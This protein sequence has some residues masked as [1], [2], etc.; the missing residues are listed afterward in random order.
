MHGCN[1][2]TDVIIA[3]A[4][5]ADARSLALMPCCYAQTAA[6]APDCL[7]SALGVALAADIQRTYTLEG[8]GYRVGWRAI[9]QSITPMNRILVANRP[10]N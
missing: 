9:P 7:R 2:L 10:S 4:A 3:A 1:K 8:L 6:N 5:E